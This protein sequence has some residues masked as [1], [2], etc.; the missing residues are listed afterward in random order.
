VVVTLLQSAPTGATR[1]FG[2][3]DASFDVVV[4]CL[5]VHDIAGADDRSTAVTE[6]LRV[7]RPGGRL[8]LAD[9]FHIEAYADTL[10]RA[11]AQDITVRSLGWRVWYGGPWSRLSMVAACRP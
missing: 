8:L 2:G 10:R 3:E 7:L 1:G 9:A 6:A 11:G 5:A 4:S